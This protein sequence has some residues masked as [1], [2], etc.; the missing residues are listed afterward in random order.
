[1]IRHLEE[2]R[3]LVEVEAAVNQGRTTDGV[4]PLYVAACNGHMEV[5]QAVM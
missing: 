1:M 3:A 4:T 2:V 5:V